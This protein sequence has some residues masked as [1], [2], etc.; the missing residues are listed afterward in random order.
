MRSQVQKSSHIQ[1]YSSI[2]SNPSGDT[3]VFCILGLP[4]ALSRQLLKQWGVCAETPSSSC[5]ASNRAI[6]LQAGVK[7]TLCIHGF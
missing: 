6:G 3:G 7:L 5:E 1:A 2:C 4:K